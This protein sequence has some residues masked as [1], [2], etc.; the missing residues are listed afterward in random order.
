MDPWQP[1]AEPARLRPYL[2]PV[3]AARQVGPIGAHPDV[4]PIRPLGDPRTEPVWLPDRTPGRPLVYVTLGTVVGTPQL[5]RELIG[6]AARVG[7]VIASLGP[8]G[9]PALLGDLPGNVAVHRFVPTRTVMVAADLL[10]HHGGMGTTLAVAAYGVPQMVV[11]QV[12]SSP[13]PTPLPAPGRPV[14][15]R[16][17]APTAPSPTPSRACTPTRASGRRPRC[18]AE[19]CRHTRPNQIAKEIVARAAADPTNP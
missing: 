8:T 10:V 13:P 17:P 1:P 15:D 11:P 3:P 5:L 14:V 2:D 18:G 4:N 19:H 9:D 12:T 6:E 16:C 7:D